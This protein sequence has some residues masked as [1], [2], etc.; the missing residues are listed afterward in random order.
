MG[1]K[2]ASPPGSDSRRA[3]TMTRLFAEL[4]IARF[5]ELYYQRRSA[6]FK[7]WAKRANIVSALAASIVLAKMLTAQDGMFFGFGPVL[8]QA[9]TGLAALSAA[10][11]PVLGLGD[12]AAQMEKA[13][14]GHA[15]VKDRIRRL[16]NDLK[17]SEIDASHLGRDSEI[18]A[19]R[20]ALAPLDEP[21]VDTLREECWEMALQEYPSEGAWS[22]I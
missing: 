5:N 12:K 3:A 2:V 19:M 17:V 21:P 9:I 13:A 14:L 4:Q 6:F 11:G 8:W 20:S 1:S 16:L 15:I 22:L 7:K 10:I 18:E